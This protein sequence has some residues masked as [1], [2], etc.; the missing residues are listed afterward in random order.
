[1]ERQSGPSLHRILFLSE[2]QLGYRVANIMKALCRFKLCIEK[3]DKDREI[4]SLVRMARETY[5]AIV[6]KY[7]L[8]YGDMIVMVNILTNG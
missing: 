5:S 6:P 3:K 7:Y 2:D 8:L 4:R 1:M